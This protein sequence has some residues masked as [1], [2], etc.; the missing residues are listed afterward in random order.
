LSLA[1]FFLLW[2]LGARLFHLP[3]YLLPPVSIVIADIASAPGWY[4]NHSLVTIGAT[5]IGFAL[6]AIVGIIAA[7]GIVH[8][9]VLEH[10]LYTLLVAMNSIP[11]PALAP[12]FII[13]LGIG[14]ESKVAISLLIALFPMVIDTVLGLRS[15]DP[16]AI[17]LARTY[18]ASPLKILWKIRFPNALPNIFAG[19]KV[20]ISLAL[21]GEIVGEFVASQNGLGH[22]ILVAQGL[23]QT[24]RVFASVILLGVIGTG[25]FYIVD[26]VERLVCPWHTA[27]R[28]GDTSHPFV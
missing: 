6:A 9:R 3:R 7:I 22:V 16:D 17:D 11:K 27:N 10:A 5:L 19:M 18:R 1:G 2:E 20:A 26:L 25:L 12:L 4:L 13:W 23:F 28:M 24:E 15:V 8:S 14:I 21:V